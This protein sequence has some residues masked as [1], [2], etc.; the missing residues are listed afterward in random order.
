MQRVLQNIIR[1]REMAQGMLIKKQWNKEK[2]IVA[3][4]YFSPI[5]MHE[6]FQAL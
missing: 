6:I 3:S 2:L 1:T 4:K 5:G